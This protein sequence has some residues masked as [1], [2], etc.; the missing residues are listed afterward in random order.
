MRKA[1]VASLALALMI[2]SGTLTFWILEP[3]PWIRGAKVITIVNQTE[4]E[5]TVL[6]VPT[7]PFAESLGDTFT[8]RTLIRTRNGTTVNT[9]DAVAYMPDMD[10]R[11]ITPRTLTSGA[12]E[13][14]VR[15][16][17]ELNPISHRTQEFP[18][19]LIYV[20]PRKEQK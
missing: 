18:L 5:A 13:A 9:T 14:R 4:G 20:Y 6:A 15:V 19:A 1:L 7:E 2:T 11:F 17:Y 16:G 10:Y 8:I 12:Y 3:D